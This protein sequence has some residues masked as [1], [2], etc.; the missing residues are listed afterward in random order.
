MSRTCPS[1]SFAALF[2]KIEIKWAAMRPG[3]VLFD[4]LMTVNGVMLI[5]TKPE[6][7]LSR[8]VQCMLSNL[9][10]SLI[11]TYSTLPPH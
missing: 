4:Y 2:L 9:T 11:R 6:C 10:C 5:N 3:K 1:L 7:A 8:K